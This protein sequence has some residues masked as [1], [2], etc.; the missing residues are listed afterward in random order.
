MKKGLKPQVL[1]SDVLSPHLGVCW[2][3]VTCIVGKNKDTV[4]HWQWR[5]RPVARMCIQRLSISH[6]SIMPLAIHP[7]IAY[8]RPFHMP[9][10]AQGSGTKQLEKR[11]RS[12]LKRPAQSTQENWK[13]HR[14]L[15]CSMDAGRG[16]LVGKVW[17]EASGRRNV[18]R[19]CL[20]P[21]TSQIKA[22]REW[23]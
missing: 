15:R 6:L 2:S 17:G 3:L 7:S 10:S 4:T 12:L 21:L 23:V 20:T 5:Q 13:V 14:L 9:G 1:V 8:P 11:A 22:I 19:Q 16:S 18:A